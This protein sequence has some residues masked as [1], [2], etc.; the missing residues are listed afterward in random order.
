MDAS[1]LRV[2]PE[3]RDFIVHCGF[4]TNLWPFKND[5]TTGTEPG[6]FGAIGVLDDGGL[7]IFGQ[8]RD[9]IYTWAD[10]DEV[11]LGFGRL[12]L[13]IRGRHA[14][15]HF[16]L[17]QPKHVA[18]LR[19]AIRAHGGEVLDRKDVLAR[20]AA[21]DAEAAAKRAAFEATKP[22]RPPMDTLRSLSTRELWCYLALDE[23][24]TLETIVALSPGESEQV[25][26]PALI[27]M[28]GKGL[29]EL[30]DSEPGARPG[31]RQWRRVLHPGPVQRE[32]AIEQ[33]EKARRVPPEVPRTKRTAEVKRANQRFP[34]SAQ[35]RTFHWAVSAG[36]LVTLLSFG[37]WGWALLLLVPAV[38]GY[39]AYHHDGE[40]QF[41]TEAAFL[42][43][44]VSLF[45]AF[46]SL[47]Y[48]FPSP[49]DE[50]APDDTPS[51][52][53]TVN[54]ERVAG[55]VADQ[56]FTGRELDNWLDNVQACYANEE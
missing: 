1:R 45:P 20:E 25:V 4:R 3:L 19:D 26:A 48:F 7:M 43:V 44:F 28:I 32:W 37:L 29:V 13:R 35:V 11:S 6:H 38:V 10:L 15:Q 33:L 42:I 31:L 14:L 22:I 9:G 30:V 54:C 12:H 51:Y 5:A 53:S 16:S 18:Q 34:T 36:V 41:S 52:G 50:P 2:T 8:G 23:P 56:G 46:V 47:A 39:A 40:F 27:S 24:T 55:W 17:T 49:P 21:A